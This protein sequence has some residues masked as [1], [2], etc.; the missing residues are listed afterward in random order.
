MS[1]KIPAP[2]SNSSITFSLLKRRRDRIFYILYLFLF[3]QSLNG[4]PQLTYVYGTVVDSKTKDPLPFIN[5]TFMNS[6]IGT[7]TGISGSYRLRSDKPVDSIIVSGVGYKKQILFV[8]R[9]VAQRLNIELQQNEH[10][11]REVVVRQGRNPAL[12]ILDS[13]LAHKEQNS[14]STLKRYEWE[15]YDKFQM[16]FG[17]YADQIKELKPF[18]EYSYIF[19]NTD[20]INGQ[21][22]LPIYMSE[23]I[24]KRF[25]D[26]SLS[27]HED[28][29]IARK[30][31]GENYENLT[32]MTDR[33]LEN[34]NIYSDYYQILDKSFVSPLI[35]N[36]QLFYNYERDEDVIIGKKL[37]YKLDF[38]PK[39]KEDF[40]FYGTLIIDPQT[41]AVRQI[42]LKVSPDI[43]LNHVKSLSITQDF[44]RVEKKW[45]MHKLET[46]VTLSALKW[47]KGEDITVHRY[48][49]YKN[50]KLSGDIKIHYLQTLENATQKLD[51]KTE[52]FWK[53]SRH[54]PLGR[55][56]KYNYT[57]ADTINH[58]PFIRRAKRVG[59]ILISGY[60]ELGK[61]SLYQANTFYSKNPIEQ[62]RL[63]FGLITNKYLSTTFQLSGYTA[64]GTKDKTFKY[65][66]GLLYVLN[67][68][69]D[70][71]IIGASYRYDLEQLGVSP[72]HIAFDNVLT[73]FSKINQKVKLTFGREASL[74]VEKEWVRKGV[75]SRLT[76]INKEIRP[77]GNV[78]FEK[79]VLE[80]NNHIENVKDLTSSEIRLNVRFSYR[81][82]FYVNEFRR[83]PLGSRY[84]I[85]ILDFTAGLKDVL[86]S[87]YNYQKLKTNLL[88]KF[89]INPA[90]YIY[91]NLEGGKIFGTVPF[92][93]A[94]LHPANQSIAYDVDG[95]NVMNYFEFASDRYISLYLD[96]HWD[97]FF[98]NKIPYVQKAKL[99]E[100]I[101]ARGVIGDLRSKNRSEM[102]LPENMSSPSKPYIEYSVG[103]E[104]IFKVL[105][106]DYIWRGT[107]LDVERENTW[108]VKARFFLTF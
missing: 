37:F 87:D 67:K 4:Y 26:D 18:R 15:Q 11:L 49:S 68:N 33:L 100:V 82:R 61:I 27:L 14:I 38:E 103:I 89:H 24:Q 76:F 64:Y 19:R 9:H 106:I 107:H 75:I 102:I 29:L 53:T 105:R 20:S 65:K 63:K 90:G 30:S 22:L 44:Q 39:W 43:N 57:I 71:A 32:T 77:M 42:N 21:A 101:S 80:K 46:W 86:H 104:N 78:R 94:T 48:T 81:E 28:L 23:T 31:T 93:L 3:F 16:Y 95:F 99:R 6:S 5:L 1:T 58:V 83:I 84:P 36:Y 12:R 17:K 13:V 92:P 54:V 88:G 7:S 85:L 96:H 52:D 66:I 25:V 69:D 8:E 62:N 56:E 10:T 73:L 45:I 40:T 60:M 2:E 47:Q 97:G 41:W 55:K 70:R 91:Y 35:N 79:R 51:E 34:K 72:N 98:F 74:Y 59:T 108:A 50:I